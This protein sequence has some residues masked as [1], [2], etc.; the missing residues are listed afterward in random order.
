MKL[1]NLDLNKLLTFLAIVEADGVTPAARRL[2]LTRS[3]VSHS[4][5][6]LETSLGVS[7]FHRVGKRLVLTR[8]GTTLRR[9]L[10]D[11]RERLGAALEA[12]L[13]AGREVRGVVRIGFVLGFSR[14]RLAR[15]I[16]ADSDCEYREQV[17]M[18]NPGPLSIWR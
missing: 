18:L 1:T 13:G 10:G 2:G 3:A 6:A 17:P 4:L 14:F 12:T 9:S 16:H 7:L 8:E 15:V 11:T 5:A